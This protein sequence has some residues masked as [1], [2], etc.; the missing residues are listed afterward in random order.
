[1]EYSREPPGT[2]T[3]SWGAHRKGAAQRVALGAH[4]G[5]DDV[6]SIERNTSGWECSDCPDK[7]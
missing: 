4:P 5:V 3:R 7:N 2:V 1:M 6:L